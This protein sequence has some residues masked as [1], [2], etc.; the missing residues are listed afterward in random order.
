MKRTSLVA[1]TALFFGLIGGVWLAEHSA[2]WRPW[3]QAAA[4]TTD[5]VSSGPVTYSS[6]TRTSPTSDHLTP[7]EERNV[8]V[9]DTANRSVVNIDTMLVETDTFF[10]TQRQAEGSGSG[11]VLDKEGHIVT[12]LHVVED[13]QKI[14]VTLASNDSYPAELVGADK[15][16]DIAVLKI[17][18]PAEKL[19]P[20]PLGKSDHLRVG[21][22]VFAL[23][24]PFGQ[25]DG[26]MT[27]G[28]ISSLNRNLPSRIPGLMMQSLIQTDAAMNPGNSGGPLLNSDAEMIGMCVAIAS[29]TG[30]NS[31]VG[32]AIP[33]DR[34]R[35]ILPELIA[36]GHVVRADIGIIDVVETDAGLVLRQV[37]PDGPA[38]Q[39]GLQ[40]WRLVTRQHQRGGFVQQ[41]TVIDRA[42]A[43]RVIAV[44]GETMR[45]GVQFR[46]KIWEHRPGDVVTLTIIRGGQQSDVPVTLGG[47]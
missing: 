13:A 35:A 31:G 6:V 5:A 43:D 44:D 1:L 34:I 32:F 47:S 22:R 24:N 28:I 41:E 2:T 11:S 29:R 7:E 46:D 4:Q 8:H 30:Q 37:T 17:D 45:T 9:Y 20:M 25:W 38:A 40:G 27:T 16:H 42:H 15:E 36:H 14:E 3:P 18:A 21:Q 39:A 26:T 10:M 23:G 19:F 33:I 12:N